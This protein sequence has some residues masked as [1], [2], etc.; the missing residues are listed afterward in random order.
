MAERIHSNG[1]GTRS[2]GG[3]ERKYGVW[4]SQQIMPSAFQMHAMEPSRKRGMVRTKHV[5]IL[6]ASRALRPG[7]FFLWP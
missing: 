2:S 7:D 4:L 1:W 5:S 3:A 6:A